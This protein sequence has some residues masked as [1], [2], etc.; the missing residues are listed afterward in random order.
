VSQSQL[1][2]VTLDGCHVPQELQKCLDGHG[3]QRDWK[4]DLLSIDKSSPRSL[5]EK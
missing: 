3:L 2:V 5:A 1:L 4:Q